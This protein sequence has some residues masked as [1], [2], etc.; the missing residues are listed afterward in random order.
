MNHVVDL[1][2]L[3]S[4]SSGN[5]VSHR[6]PQDPIGAAAQAIEQILAAAHEA[7]QEEAVRLLHAVTALL[8]AAPRH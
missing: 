1:A 7:G 6:P 3:N 8:S 5:E 4:F 2:A